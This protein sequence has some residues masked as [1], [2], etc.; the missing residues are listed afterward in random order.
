MA[1]PARELGANG[2]R[3]AVPIQR[4][5]A[6]CAI[7]AIEGDF[8]NRRE[9]QAATVALQVAVGW[10]LYG[11]QRSTATRLSRVLE[12]SSDLLFLI[13]R[14]GIE[15]NPEVA[16]RV[17]VDGLC[18]Y[19]QCDRVYLGW[20]RGSKIRLEAI[21]GVSRVDPHSIRAQPVEAA[22]REALKAGHQIDYQLDST[23]GPTTVAHA[24]LLRETDA[25]RLSSVP[26]AEGRGALLLQW[27]QPTSA[28]TGTLVEATAP[29]AVSLFS[30]LRKAHA[31]P[32]GYQI[33]RIW[34]KAT[35]HRRLIAII[36]IACLA[37]LLS[38]PFPYP[39]KV[40]CQITPTIKRI[41]AAPFDGQLRKTFV[42][43]GDQVEGGQIL[44]NLESRELLLKEADLAA[45]RERALKQRDKAMTDKVKASILLRRS[46]RSLKRTESV[47]N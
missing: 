32:C 9:V 22:M 41:V 27:N 31:F 39:I 17:A 20:T 26:L 34:N 25:A 8:Q 35:N 10:V 43:P 44:G 5:G 2:W 12:R 40:D 47:R 46:S 7:L 30:L 18:D 21:S 13:Q 3:I 38:W 1:T 45:G 23:T 24:L 11:D 6:I 37:A 14:A 4:D 16:V 28:D 29:Y 15:E 36:A 42:E 33:A 19:L